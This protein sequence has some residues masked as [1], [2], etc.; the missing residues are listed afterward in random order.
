M[1]VDTRQHV[2]VVFLPSLT[3]S[4]QSLVQR[5]LAALEAG[6]QLR[7]FQLHRLMETELVY[8]PLQSRLGKM[9]LR[10]WLTEQLHDVSKTSGAFLFPSVW[11]LQPF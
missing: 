4:L 5:I 8:M 9:F 7:T 1:P 2:L 11:S 6:A 10:S 3:L